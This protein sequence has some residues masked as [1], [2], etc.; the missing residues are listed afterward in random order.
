[1][2][3][4][5]NKQGQASCPEKRKMKKREKKNSGN[6]ASNGHN[7]R[8]RFLW[9]AL[10]L[11]C[12]GIASQT[13]SAQSTIT[14][15][16]TFRELNPWLNSG[17]PAG[18]V[19]NPAV[20]FSVAGA[21]YGFS[22]GS[23]RMSTDA[24][25]THRYALH[26]ESFQTLKKVQLYG[27]AGYS[28]NIRK[29][30]QWSAMLQP[31]VHLI[32]LGDS[33]PGRR[34]DETYNICG[35]IA[36][37]LTPCWN[38]GLNLDYNARAGNK[39]SNPR[40]KH[41][42]NDVLF[43]PGLAFSCGIFRAG[44][45]FTFHRIIENVTYEFSNNELYTFQ[46]FLPLW[47]YVDENISNGKNK[48]RT[49]QDQSYGGGVQFSFGNKRWEWFNEFRYS[50]STAT[51]DISIPTGKRAGETERRNFN[52]T[53]RLTYHASLLHRLQPEYRRLL[54]TGYDN[55]QGPPENAASG[56][57]EDYG[58]I[59][60]SSFITDEATL[61][62][63]LAR[64][65]DS[66]VNRWAVRTRFGYKHEKTLFFVYPA[67][68]SQSITRLSFATGYERRIPIRKQLLEIGAGIEYTTGHGHLPETTTLNGSPMPD[69]KIQQN[70]ALLNNDFQTGTA[71]TLIGNLRLQYTRPLGSVFS[72]YAS[73]TTSYIHESA[74]RA[75]ARFRIHQDFSAGILF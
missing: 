53:G 48:F 51:T 20:R 25:D 19:F 42:Q 40:Y 17:N 3:L 62:Y 68:L 61:N 24:P 7:S 47:F 12:C 11:V 10:L 23:H 28:G 32:S 6:P 4:R 75:Q 58:R 39:N 16:E 72:F 5:K 63:T 13:L 36:I 71:E 50:G 56:K 66:F 57:V 55:L 45:N 33:F 8:N 21:T 41:T 59:R 15:S 73:A 52:Y 34:H 67:S 74:P 49:Y 44:A 26:S 69:I 38:I 22:N 29:R 14:R 18:L 46:T 1:M 64:P 9:F 31:E 35:G 37:P 30:H 70:Q 27:K 43:S 60:R 54:R 65:Y 2:I